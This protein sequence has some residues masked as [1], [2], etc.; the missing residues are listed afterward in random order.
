MRASPSPVSALR[1]ALGVLAVA[2]FTL[3]LRAADAAR[4]SVR[5]LTI[6]NSFAD[7]ATTY[8]PDLAKAGGKDLV[9]FRAN[10]GGCSLERHARH[11]AAALADP[12]ATD[13]EARP[14]K[15][16]PAVT[17][18]AD[19]KTVSLLDALKARP[20]DYV[21]IQQ[22]SHQSFK[23]ESYEPYAAQLIA[24]IRQLAP[25]AE[26]LVHQTWAYREDHPFFKKD[27]GFTPLAMYEQSRAAYHALA[28]R[29]GDLRLLPSGDA[30]HLA[31]QTPRWTFAPDPA[32]DYANPPSDT[33]P[34]QRASLQTGWR[35]VT[36]KD[37]AEKRFELDAIHCNKAGDYLTGAVWYQVLFGTT[38]IPAAYSPEGLAPEDA[39]DL[40]A[41]ARAAV[42]GLATHAATR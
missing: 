28:A 33:V 19:L 20:W 18:L 37:T 34:D 35:W 41:H 24:A 5:V 27:D 16:N 8:L 38:D 23:P 42:A 7:D 1:L 11:L 13:V 6:G 12:A 40:R 39:A 26:I 4:D 15:N 2:V 9:L 10:L 32:F 29:Y 22:V 30:L 36:K 25:Q 21:T 17:G 31:R 14:Y 3:P